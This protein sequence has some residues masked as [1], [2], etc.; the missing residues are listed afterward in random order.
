MSNMAVKTWKTAWLWIQCY[1]FVSSCIAE[2]TEH[3][4]MK[5]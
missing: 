1:R 2:T 3:I 5:L 4:I